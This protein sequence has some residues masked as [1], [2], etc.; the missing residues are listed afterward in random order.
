MAWN[1]EIN[2]LDESPVIDNLLAF[3]LANQTEA[4]AWANGGAGLEDFKE[5]YS[6]ANGRLGSRFPHLMIVNAASAENNQETTA[7]V[8]QI[9]IEGALTGPNADAV[10][11]KEYLYAK[12]VKSM[13]ANVPVATLFATAE[14]V[15]TGFFSGIEVSYD[16]I[17]SA[18]G[19][20]RQA[21]LQ[22][23]QIR[24]TYTLFIEGE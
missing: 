7:N 1:P 8:F 2:T 19:G 10:T 15:P 4:L 3:I 12:A 22:V 6:S 23:F 21:F 11:T 16:T 14:I 13:L 5:L 17:G 20:G 24:A 9:L 18:A